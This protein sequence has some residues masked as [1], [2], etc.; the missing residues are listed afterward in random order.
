MRE[1]KIK[2]REAQLSESEPAVTHAR[3]GFGNGKGGR[4][5][6]TQG[7]RGKGEG[8]MLDC[9]DPTWPGRCGHCGRKQRWGHA[10][11]MHDVH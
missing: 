1:D 9:P 11:A 8:S 4:N 5:V 2:H 3:E 10:N 7:G 6:D